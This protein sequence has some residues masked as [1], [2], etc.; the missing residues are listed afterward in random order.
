MTRGKNPE[1]ICSLFNQE[2]YQKSF[3]KHG[4]KISHF[5]KLQI[6]LLHVISSRP[7]FSYFPFS[8]GP[9]SCIGQLF[10]QVSKIL[11]LRM[12]IPVLI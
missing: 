12:L 7:Y 5:L 11:A 3:L 4:E 10:A 2:V 6:K 9:R 8:L 1:P